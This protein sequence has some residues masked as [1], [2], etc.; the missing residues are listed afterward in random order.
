MLENYLFEYKAERTHDYNLLALIDQLKQCGKSHLF[1]DFIIKSPHGLGDFIGGNTKRAFDVLLVFEKATIVI[2]TK[3]DSG[4]GFYEGRWQTAN[5]YQDFCNAWPDNPTYFL[6]LTYG[7]AEH[8]IKEREDG[9]YGNGPHS[10]NFVHVKC[11][12]ILQFVQQAIKVI[13]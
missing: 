4:E 7:L 2:E 12:E 1:N 13:K 10:K 5:I 8:Y 6:Y 9:S 11:N 3:V